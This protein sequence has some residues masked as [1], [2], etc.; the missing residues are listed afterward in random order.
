[1]HEDNS[2][3]PA[4]RELP[5][6]FWRA[7][8]T[9]FIAR[10]AYQMGKT[11]VLPL[12]A[13]AVGAGEVLIGL[14]VAVSTTTG[15]L[16]K[17]LFGALSDRWGR[18]VWWFVALCLL[19][20]MPLLYHFVSTPEQL[21]G[22][23]FVH[24]TA[25]AILG[26]VT[27]AYIVEL[28]RSG[29][30]TRLAWF[31]MARE[32]G[33]LV[34][35]ALAGWMLTFMAPADVFTV[36]GLVS[37]AAFAP[38]AFIRFDGDADRRA[39]DGRVVGGKNGGLGVSPLAVARDVIRGLRHAS[40]R[41]ATWIAGGLETAIYFVTYGLKAFLPLFA[42]HEGGFG[43]L[44]AGLFFTIQEAAHLLARPL[45]G[46]VGDRIGYPMA[47]SAGMMTL[48]TALWLISGA[49]TGVML[50]AAAIVSGV[51]QGLVFP[52]TVA[53]VGDAAGDAHIGAGMGLYG[54]LRNLGKISGPVVTGMALSVTS[55]DVVFSSLAA[56][57]VLSALFLLVATGRRQAQ[58]RTA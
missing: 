19:A 51:G 11:P 21:M 17:P 1:M 48:A 43:V 26:P 41:G 58:R 4:L 25:T 47:I 2:H 30:A 14:I 31:G 12:F 29:R 37:C 6:T 36:V 33:Y 40:T 22:L 8:A 34:A 18:R 5:A 27:L 28:G 54:M 23:R 24:G 15:M 53:L 50:L 7:F 3:A 45:G 42:I 9:D 38:F 39:A 52:S 13:A 55:F 46:W 44:V 32:G 16:T 10:S 56:G 20:G 49:E 57:L 35:P